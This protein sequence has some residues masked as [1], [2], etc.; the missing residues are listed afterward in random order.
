MRGASD[1]VLGKS[2]QE[3]SSIT[4]QKS[5]KAPSSFEQP[6]TFGQECLEETRYDVSEGF[7]FNSFSSAIPVMGSAHPPFGPNPYRSL[8]KL[9]DLP[10]RTSKKLASCLVCVNTVKRHLMQSSR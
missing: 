7:V 3:I 5:P 2:I 8:L 6:S 9:K 4:M 1:F 10:L